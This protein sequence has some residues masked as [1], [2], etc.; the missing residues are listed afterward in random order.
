MV[1]KVYV[2]IVILKTY[3]PK[4]LGYAAAA[5]PDELMT[6]RLQSL[7]IILLSNSGLL[8]VKKWIKC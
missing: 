4:L 8:K 5:G 1:T 6:N 2:D 7:H 3:V